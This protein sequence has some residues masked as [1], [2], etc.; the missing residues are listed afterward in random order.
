MGDELRTVLVTGGAG[1]IGS[2]LAP[3]LLRTGRRVVVLDRCYFGRGGLAEVAKAPGFT[4][5]DADIRDAA[6]VE[7][8]LRTHRPDAVIHL[9]AISNDPCSDLDPELTRHVN[10]RACSQVM[11]ASKAAGV[12]RFL[13]ASSAS[14]YGIKEVPDVTEDMALD[15]ITVYA[16]CKAAGEDVL[17]GL[18][19]ASFCGVSVRAATVCGWSPRLRLDLTI[20]ILTHHALTAGRIRVFGGSQMRPNVHILDLADFYT[21]LLEQPADRVA[22]RAF[23]VCA[24]NATVMGLAEMVRGELDPQ[25][26]IDVVPTADIRSYHLS[27]ERAR[28]ELGF[29]PRRPLSLAVAELRAA[30]ADGRVSDPGATVY[31]NVEVMKAHAADWRW[32]GDR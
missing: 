11:T 9:A 19:D 6:A 23:N 28:R 21:D 13:Y 25:L 22:G 1:Y 29:V 20:N 4:L 3:R 16:E 18:V 15:P 24:G 14:V 8:A 26:P 32:G 2:R 12:R 7:A 31:R 10:L 5:V 30:Y 17:N 27:A